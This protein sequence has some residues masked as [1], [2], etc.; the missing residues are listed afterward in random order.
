MDVVD[1]FGVD[2]SVVY[3]L[4]WHNLLCLRVVV[5]DSAADANTIVGRVEIR[6]N[7]VDGLIGPPS[8]RNTWMAL[9]GLKVLPNGPEFH[10]SHGPHTFRF[11]LVGFVKMLALLC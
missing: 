11:V 10:T 2:S 3:C 9:P 8:P 7:A 1:L 6:M 4:A 5:G